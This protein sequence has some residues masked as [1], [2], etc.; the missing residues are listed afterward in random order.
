M[1]TLEVLKNYF[2]PYMQ[3][4]TTFCKYM[5]KEYLQLMILDYLSTTKYVD[6]LSF[7]GGTN[8]RLVKGIDRFS[9]DLDFDCKDLSFEEFISLTDSVVTMLRRNG[10]NVQTKEKEN[11]KLSAFRRSLYFPELLFNFELTGHREERFLIKLESQDQG[12]NYNTIVKKI[13]GCGYFFPF[14][15]P[16]DSV[17][18]AM[19]LTAMIK[20]GK[21][22]DFYDA[23]FLL[24]ITQPDYSFL[25]NKCN[26]HNL[27]GLKQEVHAL[28]TK[29]NLSQ[30]TMDFQH[31]LFNKE[32]SK[33]ILQIGDFI[34]SL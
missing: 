15:M 3:E 23:M 17:L 32:N 12:F 11:E 33:K 24:S 8:L 22:R 14:R 7:I 1:I 34:D 10:F 19:K 13:K 21:G 31:L 9:E 28:L 26:I 27:T 20:R 5:I 25:E 18:C 29:T 30:K 16:T 2:P 6:K 4:N